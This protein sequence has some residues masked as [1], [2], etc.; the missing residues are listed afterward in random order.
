[1]CEENKNK[2]IDSN[3]MSIEFVKQNPIKLKNIVSISFNSWSKWDEVTPSEWKHIFITPIF[4]K[5]DRN[6]VN[7]PYTLVLPAPSEGY[8]EEEQSGVRAGR[9]LTNNILCPR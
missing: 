2:A 8:M 3:G 6:I 1:M 7:I 4:K 5:A 9:Y